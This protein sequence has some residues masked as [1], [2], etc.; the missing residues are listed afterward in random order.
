MISYF[1]TVLNGVITGSHTG[2]IKVDFFGTPY[3]NHERIEVPKD[4]YASIKEFDKVEYYDKKWKRKPDSQLVKE[5]IIPMP[6]GY[7]W[8]GDDLRRLS[9][10]E[11]IIAG[12]DSPPRGY[13][14]EGC[15]I[16]ELTPQE[17]VT[18]GII[19]QDAYNSQIEQKNIEELKRRLAEL[20]DPILLAKAERDEELKKE[21]D[22]K[23]D[24]LLSIEQ[25]PGWPLDVVWLD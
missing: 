11:R 17:K 7:R 10:E 5:K 4:V 19:T 9:T 16:V 20:M 21:R 25:Q 12:L 24:I 22:A 23:V 13:K 2:N 1:I 15:N 18:A 14:V 8:E 6:E 3:Y